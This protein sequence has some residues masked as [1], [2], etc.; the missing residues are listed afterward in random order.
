MVR[1]RWIPARS[2]LVVACLLS[3]AL[4]VSVLA[5]A[6]AQAQGGDNRTEVSFAARNAAPYS[7][8]VRLEVGAG[9]DVRGCTGTIIDDDSV[10]TAAHCL[11]NSSTGLLRLPQN[12]KVFYGGG[13]GTYYAPQRSCVARWRYIAPEYLNG[14]SP[15]YDYGVVNVACW[16]QS[17]GKPAG[18]GV[19]DADFPR[20]LARLQ[21]SATP[22]EVGNL[23]G[24]VG[25]TAGFPG[26]KGSLTMWGAQ[27]VVVQAQERSFT[28]SVAAVGGQSGSPIWGS[29]GGCT[30]CVYGVLSSRTGEGVSNP[31]IFARLSGTA[32]N[33]IRSWAAG[34]LIIAVDCTGSMGSARE[35]LVTRVG[36]L[37]ETNPEGT[38]VAVACWNDPSNLQVL[39]AF[40]TD[41]ALVKTALANLVFDGGGDTPEDPLGALTEAAALGTWNANT[42]ADVLLVTDAGMKE[43][44][45]TAE[46][47]TPDVVAK[48]AAGPTTTISDG[49]FGSAT[50]AD[51]VADASGT[52]VVTPEPAADTT[53]TSPDAPADAPAAPVEPGEAPTDAPV[54]PADAG[55][56][57]AQAPAPADAPDAPAGTGEAPTDTP[58]APAD[59]GPAPAEA[60]APTDAPTDTTAAEPVPDAP[61]VDPVENS[62]DPVIVPTPTY[63]APEVLPQPIT[64]SVAIVGGYL[65]PEEIDQYTA[66]STPPGGNVAVDTG[67]GTLDQLLQ[68]ITS[69][70]LVTT[71]GWQ[72][73]LPAV[74]PGTTTGTTTGTVSGP[75]V[76]VAE[77]CPSDVDGPAQ[78]FAVD[79][80]QPATDPAK[81]SWHAEDATLF[82][83]L[84]AVA[85]P[86]G[87][88]PAV[89]TFG[90]TNQV[91]L[92]FP[93]A[94]ALPASPTDVA[95]GLRVVVEG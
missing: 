82:A 38:K 10:L 22:E 15:G 45:P 3:A 70:P 33:R 9:D 65:S 12:I 59:A 91:V 19:Y 40:T 27:G 11:R 23:N 64:V 18:E 76:P 46:L 28:A 1:I 32:R 84:A 30:N 89:A 39:Q 53:G 31:T 88:L 7:G 26:D 42:S 4:F 61:V 75:A 16:R 87:A 57:P 50:A 71:T 60:P 62:S 52:P 6:S 74:P 25:Y 92:C 47:T 5:P 93:G 58:V 63:P 78:A 80:A 79:L 67:G 43:P 55:P 8:V 95:A 69:L 24:R 37:M 72:A 21:L 34:H 29:I 36:E 66:L 56:A 68:T 54:A 2:V 14:F 85:G 13:D 51:A 20:S 48:L 90:R 17:P 44:S 83:G 94:A 41:P 35:E 81:V 73:D 49:D 86:E 77:G